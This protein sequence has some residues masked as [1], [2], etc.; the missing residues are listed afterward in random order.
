MRRY[1]L[2]CEEG[3]A[4][5]IEALAREHDLTQEAVIRQLL[6]AGLEEVDGEQPGV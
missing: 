1:E 6:D 4:E 3:L 5:E 2:L